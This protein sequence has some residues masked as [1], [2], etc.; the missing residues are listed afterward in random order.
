MIGLY[1]NKLNENFGRIG[2]YTDSYCLD[3]Y[4][5]GDNLENENCFWLIKSMIDYLIYGEY[6]INELNIKNIKHLEKIYYNK[7]NIFYQEINNTNNNINYNNNNINYNIYEYFFNNKIFNNYTNIIPNNLNQKKYNNFISLSEIMKIILL[8]FIPLL[9][10]LFCCL[11]IIKI[12]INKNRRMRRNALKS[13][14]ELKPLS[15]IRKEKKRLYSVSSESS[16]VDIEIS[17]NNNIYE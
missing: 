16:L 11:I 6:T 14:G 12:K 3:D 15:L 17:V 4:Q 13:L 2:I 1:E 5:L 9:F 7:E 8:L 10:V